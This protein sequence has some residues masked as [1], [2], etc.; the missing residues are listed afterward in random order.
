MFLPRFLLYVLNEVIMKRKYAS[1][2]E[3]LLKQTFYI[4]RPASSIKQN[5]KNQDK[6]K[7][8]KLLKW[9]SKKNIFNAFYPVRAL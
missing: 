6:N 5:I 8:C 1:E 3:S 9:E 7:T 4:G 2:E